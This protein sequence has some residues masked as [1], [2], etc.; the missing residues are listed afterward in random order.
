M[1]KRGPLNRAPSSPNPS[2]IAGSQVLIPFP[3]VVFAS[4]MAHRCHV[5][6]FFGH[7]MIVLS[8]HDF[9]VCALQQCCAGPRHE[10]HI[11]SGGQTRQ[12][13]TCFSKNNDGQHEDHISARVGL[14]HVLGW[15][16]RNWAH[17]KGD[18]RMIQK[19]DVLMVISQLITCF[20]SEGHG[21]ANKMRIFW[22]RT[23]LSASGSFFQETLGPT[24]ICRAIID[25]Q[26]VPHRGVA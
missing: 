7:A 26:H 24:S 5:H 3:A 14:P 25:L 23:I 10:S 6:T 1:R 16:K 22:T 4:S 9:Y 8:T 17:S 13:K 15:L 11:D 20:E 21:D 19:T 18:D 2:L 12:D